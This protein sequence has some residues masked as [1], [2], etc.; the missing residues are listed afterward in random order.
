MRLK[1]LYK[2]LSNELA[3]ARKQG[4]EYIDSIEQ[5]GIKIFDVRQFSN[6]LSWK[7]LTKREQT[8]SFFYSLTDYLYRDR[9]YTKPH[10]LHVHIYDVPITENELYEKVRSKAIKSGIKEEA[11]HLRTR[12]DHPDLIEI[13]TSWASENGFNKVEPGEKELSSISI[14]I[15]DDDYLFV[16]LVKDRRRT[17]NRLVFTSWMEDLAEFEKLS[18]ELLKSLD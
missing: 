12:S 13:V 5:D 15:N 14:N 1:K 9:I 3:E 2:K 11:I 6:D 18:L 16:K 17:N 7:E 4:K 8:E 10:Y